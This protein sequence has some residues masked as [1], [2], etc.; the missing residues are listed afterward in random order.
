MTNTWSIL[1]IKSFDEI[2]VSVLLS[3]VY[4]Q[5]QAPFH[6]APLLRALFHHTVRE[7]YLR[8]V[9]SHKSHSE[10]DKYPT[11][12]HFVTEMSTVTKWC[13]VGYG[14]GAMWEL[15]DRSIEA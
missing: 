9:P 7:E 12:H 10:S 8:I 2:S 13:I 5:A 6:P 4:F 11:M 3:Y 15:C 14:T 1:S